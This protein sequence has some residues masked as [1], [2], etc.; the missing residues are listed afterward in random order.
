MRWHLL[1]QSM[2]P[3]ATGSV[4]VAH[5]LSCPAACGI[6]PNFRDGTCVSVLAGK[7][8]TLDS[9]RSPVLVFLSFFYNNFQAFF[10]ICRL[11]ET[12]VLKF[13]LSFS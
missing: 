1:S 6:V 12:L 11:N 9:Q 2:G 8:P 10:S 7:F 3:R 13:S 4:I 5:G